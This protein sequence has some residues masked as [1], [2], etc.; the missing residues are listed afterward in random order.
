MLVS[1][2]TPLSSSLRIGVMI[3]AM[4][5]FLQCSVCKL[6]YVFPD[7]E[8]FDTV[9]KQFAAYPCSSAIGVPG[10]R[11]A[12]I[13]NALQGTV[14]CLLILRYQGRIPMM[15]SCSKCERK[16]FTPTT[17]SGTR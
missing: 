6:S 14:R 8:Q 12:E 4:G 1:S 15:A 10:S 2:S 3:S 5:R 9:A 11:V 7:N 13:V 16:F 17:F